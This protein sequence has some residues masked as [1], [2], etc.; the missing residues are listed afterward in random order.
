MTERGWGGVRVLKVGEQNCPS[1]GVKGP[2]IRGALQN[3]PKG[4]GER[5]IPL[6]F[7][8]SQ[9]QTFRKSKPVEAGGLGGSGGGMIGS[10]LKP[11]QDTD[12][13]LK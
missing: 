10:H 4:R 7:G 1:N 9:Q 6:P 13:F 8:Q 5:K 12:L 2:T 11:T 3:Q